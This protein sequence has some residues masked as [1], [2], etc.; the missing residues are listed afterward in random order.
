MGDPIPCHVCHLDIE[1]RYVVVRPKSSAAGHWVHTDTVA[2]IA[3][4]GDHEALR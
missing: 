1:M 4:D 2:G 3:A